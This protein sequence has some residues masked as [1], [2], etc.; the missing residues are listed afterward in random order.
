MTEYRSLIKDKQNNTDHNALLAYF[1]GPLTRL[2]G[3]T[4]F[5]D[6]KIV[7]DPRRSLVLG[8]RSSEPMHSIRAN[9]YWE[10]QFVLG[11][12]AVPRSRIRLQTLQGLGVDRHSVKI[13]KQNC[14]SPLC[15]PS[16]AARSRSCAPP[17]QSHS[18]CQ[19]RKASCG[20]TS[21]VRRELGHSK[22]CVCFFLMCACTAVVGNL[23]RVGHAVKIKKQKMPEM[24]T[25]F[26]QCRSLKNLLCKSGF[27]IQSRLKTKK[28]KKWAKLTSYEQFCF[29]IFTECRS[30]MQ[31]LTTTV[32]SSI[33]GTGFYLRQG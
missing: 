33:F 16:W 8:T 12:I 2:G 11:Y 24:G 6:S 4:D 25:K 27:G 31:I 1:S 28:C 26:T 10:F 17:R 23:G 30:L 15:A 14:K 32:Q 29:L 18:S 3:S 13:K 5:G 9:L 19:R 7:W 21:W 22:V 20:A